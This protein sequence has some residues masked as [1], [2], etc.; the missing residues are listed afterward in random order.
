MVKI[1]YAITMQSKKFFLWPTVDRPGAALAV[2]G[3]YPGAIFLY[4]GLSWAISGPVAVVLCPWGSKGT[5]SRLKS[6]SVNTYY[7]E[8]Q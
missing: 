1:F 2:L 5:Y 4:I 3:R 7:V 8:W 6:T